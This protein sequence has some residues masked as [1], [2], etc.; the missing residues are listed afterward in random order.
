MSEPLLAPELV[1]KA[2]EVVAANIAAGRRVAVAESCT[3]GLV[4][5]AI[6]EIPGSSA[7]FEAGYVL[8]P[9]DAP[10]LPD[11]TRELFGFPQ[12]RHDDQVDSITQY[13]AWS[14]NHQTSIFEADFGWDT[15]PT[16]EDIAS[17]PLYGRG[18]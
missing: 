9:V 8:F 2:R 14:R 4:S 17:R 16:P 10:W 5:A 13:L 11:L 15:D 3:G 12:T 18:L 6:T 1:A 7:M